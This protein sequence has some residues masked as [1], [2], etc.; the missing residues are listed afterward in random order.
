[1]PDHTNIRL[2]L[3]KLKLAHSG[4]QRVTKQLFGFYGILS[5][6]EKDGIDS[7]LPLWPGGG[8]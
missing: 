2:V 1:M 4:A 6:Y 7:P 3:Y 8:T 5:W